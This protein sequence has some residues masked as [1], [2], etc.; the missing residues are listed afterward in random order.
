MVLDSCESWSNGIKRVS[1]YKK[2]SQRLWAFPP[3]PHGLRRL[4]I[5][6]PDP[7]YDNSWVT[8]VYSHTS[9]TL[10]THIPQFTHLHFWF[11][12]STS[13]KILVSCKHTGR[14]FWS[15]NLQNLFPIKSSFLFRKFMMTP[16]N[17][18]CGCPPPSKVLA[19]PMLHLASIYATKY[20]KKMVKRKMVIEQIIKFKIN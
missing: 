17:V 8:L 6:P 1:F 11:K 14:G 18:I 12:S 5:P 20:F 2:I 4:G 15:S 19:T 3:D 9:P 7:V 16:L 13:S 10:L